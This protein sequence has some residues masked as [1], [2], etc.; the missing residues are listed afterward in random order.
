MKARGRD[1][2]SRVI[3]P[4]CAA[5]KRSRSPPR[6]H[7]DIALFD[8][9]RPP[10]SCPFSLSGRPH[11]PLPSCTLLKAGPVFQPALVC[12]P[13][14]EPPTPG[15]RV[16]SDCSV[17]RCSPVLPRALIA[18]AF[19][20]QLPSPASH[21]VALLFLRPPLVDSSATQ[22]RVC[23]PVDVDYACLGETVCC[24]HLPKAT[25]LCLLFL[26]PLPPLY[27]I[28]RPLR[29]DWWKISHSK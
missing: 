14:F 19:T 21:C 28:V 22:G 15:Q 2:C 3:C 20:L 6:T 18:P 8:V 5:T 4:K 17:A 23:V 11:S 1:L 25:P 9:P 13:P 26:P 10:S 29:S 16:E 24:R 7:W 12:S 27:L